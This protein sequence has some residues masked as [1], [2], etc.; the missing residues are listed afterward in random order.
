MF[1]IKSMEQVIAEQTSGVRV[2]A[3]TMSMYAVIGLLLAAT[4]IYA[5]ISYSVAQ[6]THEIGV[7]VALGA[8]RR[9][10]LRMVVGQAF[11]VAVL[12]LGIGIPVAY[13]LT[14]VMSSAL[15]NV[16]AVDPMT[17]AALA[18]VP[19]LFWAS[20]RLYSRAPRCKSRPCGGAPSRMTE[21][22]RS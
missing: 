3:N 2:S 17:F 16:V 20:G 11:R 21:V 6:R 9:E 4:G 5:V 15:L 7:R 13:I 14:R 18:C 12:G 19:G 10:I 1:D 8:G 22:D